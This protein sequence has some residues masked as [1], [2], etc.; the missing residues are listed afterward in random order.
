[1]W[2]EKKEGEEEPEWVKSEREQFRDYRDKN[3][4]GKMDSSEVQE[5][6]IPTDYDHALAETKHLMYESDADKVGSSARHQSSVNSVTMA[7]TN[8]TYI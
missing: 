8:T 6:I 2:R 3:K 5:W 7:K 1:M 4:D